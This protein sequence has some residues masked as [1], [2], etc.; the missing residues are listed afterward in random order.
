MAK[1]EVEVT[2]ILK[3]T[4]CVEADSLEE[5]KQKGHEIVMNGSISEYETESLGTESIEANVLDKDF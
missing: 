1:Y 5:A 2:E 3:H 4:A